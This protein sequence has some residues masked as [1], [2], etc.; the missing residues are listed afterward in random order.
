M[1]FVLLFGLL[2]LAAPSFGQAWTVDA[3][4]VSTEATAVGGSTPV[5][6][7]LEGDGAG[8]T[9]VL[10]VTCAR[11]Q[12]SVNSAGASVWFRRCGNGLTANDANCPRT[13]T[14]AFD[15]LTPETS[16]QTLYGNTQVF[17]EVVTEG[18]NAVVTASCSE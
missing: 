9:S 7:A 2:L 16:Q 17:V 6:N 11:V 13:T 18:T 5:Y 1:R 8:D 14:T 3:A 12:L 4:G 10:S 15:G